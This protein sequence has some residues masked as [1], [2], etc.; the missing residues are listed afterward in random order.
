MTCARDQLQELLDQA[1]RLRKDLGTL[2]GFDLR[3]LHEV[4]QFMADHVPDRL[5]ILDRAIGT[6]AVLAR[7]FERLELMGIAAATR[8]GLAR[9]GLLPGQVVEYTQNR[10]GAKVER[11]RVDNCPTYSLGDSID[12]P[13]SIE[14]T[15]IRADGSLGKRM[16]SIQIGGDRP[17]PFRPLGLWQ[18]PESKRRRK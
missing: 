15:Q 16:D 5:P 17:T 8:Y 10:R 2:D 12:D 14:G 18:P 1:L 4:R 6:E 13:I 7:M 11:M 9:A 3:S